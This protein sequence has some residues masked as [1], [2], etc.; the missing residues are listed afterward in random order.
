M[1]DKCNFTPQKL[2]TPSQS[3]DFNVHTNINIF[4]YFSLFSCA[5]YVLTLYLSI[6]LNLIHSMVSSLKREFIGVIY[7]SWPQAHCAP[8]TV[9]HGLTK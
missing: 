7:S 5:D 9:S 6:Y 3:D 4:L 2:S 1:Y 8:L